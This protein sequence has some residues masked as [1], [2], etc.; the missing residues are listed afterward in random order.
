[1]SQ[2]PLPHVLE[3]TPLNPAFRSDPHAMFDRLRSECPVMRDEMAGLFLLT[4]YEDVRGVVT[5]L[6]LLRDPSRAEPGAFLTR[7]GLEETIEGFA[8]Q[9]KPSILN[10]DDPDQARIRPPLAQALY[11]RVAKF[12]PAVEEIVKTTMDAI[13]YPTCFDLM[14]AFAVPIPIDVIAAILG[15][16][17]IRPRFSVGAPMK[18]LRYLTALTVISALAFAADGAK[19]AKVADCCAKATKDGKACTHECCVAAAKD[20]KNCEKCGGAGMITKKADKK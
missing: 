16:D 15:V 5:D 8:R 6:S 1:M 11:R 4:R 14:S 9:G 17:A 12:R 3:L 10:L 18:L 7:R 13:E 2:G 19:E 20:G